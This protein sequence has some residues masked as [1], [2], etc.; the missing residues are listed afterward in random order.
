M[1]TKLSIKHIVE[2]PSFLNNDKKLLE[3][4]I[5]ELSILGGFANPENFTDHF[6][7]KIAITPSQYIKSLKK[8]DDF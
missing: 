7:R 1:N 3:K 2:V 5:K 6:K 8:E 4:N